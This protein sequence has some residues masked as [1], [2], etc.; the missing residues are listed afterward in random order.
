MKYQI[1]KLVVPQVLVHYVTDDGL[2]SED[3]WVRIDAKPDGTLPQGEELD[4][5]ILSFA[6]VL[7]KP[8]LITMYDWSHIQQLVPASAMIN[9][10][11]T[12]QIVS[13]FVDV[14]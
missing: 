9:E 5:Y 8:N 13:Q 11:S 3:L 10:Q 6:P 2:H 12:D 1:I 4:A 7:P 14:K